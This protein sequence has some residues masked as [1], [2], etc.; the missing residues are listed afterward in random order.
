MQT[1]TEEEI[2]V[3]Y[4]WYPSGLEPLDSR[5]KRTALRAKYL[6]SAT[7]DPQTVESA[8]AHYIATRFPGQPAWVNLPEIERRRHIVNLLAKGSET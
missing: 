4:P 5:V 7:L 1:V 8:E 3:I 2:K 6:F